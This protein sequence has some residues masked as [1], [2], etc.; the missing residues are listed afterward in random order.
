[1]FDLAIAVYSSICLTHLS[2]LT[3]H[4]ISLTGAR[5]GAG[6]QKTL[7]KQPCPERYVCVPY[8]CMFKSSHIYI[9]QRPEVLNSMAKSRGQISKSVLTYLQVFAG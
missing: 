9:R 4:Q 7:M 3:S 6:Q 5:H 8:L 1:M 2:V